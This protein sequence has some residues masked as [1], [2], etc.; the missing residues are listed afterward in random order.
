MIFGYARV[1]TRSQASDGNSLESQRKSLLDAGAKEIFSDTYSG[2]STERPALNKL[3][4]SIGNNDTLIVTKLDRIARS[5]RQG[6]ELIDK[7]NAKN[8]SVKILNMGTIDNSPIGKLMRTML[9]GF[10]EFERDLILERTSEGKKIARKNPN[11][12]EGRPQKF[13]EE[14]IQH[15]LELLKEHS[16]SQVSKMTGISVPTLVRKKRDF[17][18]QNEI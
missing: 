18:A 8:V 2:I 5:A 14:Q 13:K 9:F 3:M 16:F 10:A 7:L 1:S 4:D 17:K 6:L 12:R 11:Y 15:A